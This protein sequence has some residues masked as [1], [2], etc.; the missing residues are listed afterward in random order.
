MEPISFSLLAWAGV[1]AFTT[2]GVSFAAVSVIGEGR[3][4]EQRILEFKTEE[5]IYKAYRD[6]LL[7]SPMPSNLLQTK[8][9]WHNASI[10]TYLETHLGN[11]KA[12]HLIMMLVE[13]SEKILQLR[14]VL[15][16]FDT[17][18]V[19]IFQCFILESFVSA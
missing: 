2:A 7:A 1:G 8:D 13:T 9:L 11:E 18:S 14:K 5:I 17:L 12:H 16:H 15:I 19:C 10:R 4:I 6:Q 3:Q